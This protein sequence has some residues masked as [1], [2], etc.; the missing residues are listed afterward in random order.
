MSPVE[1][2]MLRQALPADEVAARSLQVI[3]F[4][5]ACARLDG[6]RRRIVLALLKVLTEDNLSPAEALELIAEVSHLLDAD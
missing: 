2:T 5:E 1:I 3:Q 6:I 4:G